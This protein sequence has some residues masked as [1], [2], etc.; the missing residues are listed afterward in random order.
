MRQTSKRALR[1]QAK[2]HQILILTKN[3]QKLSSVYVLLLHSDLLGDER[4][5]VTNL[6]SS[7]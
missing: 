7:L 6:K 2:S 5:S 3:T 1:L 4:H